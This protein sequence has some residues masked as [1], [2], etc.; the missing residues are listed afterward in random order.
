MDVVYELA[1]LKGLMDMPKQDAQRIRVS[2]KLPAATRKDRG[3]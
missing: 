1:A 2:S 3:S